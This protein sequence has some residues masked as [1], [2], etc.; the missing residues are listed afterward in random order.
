MTVFLYP[1]IKIPNGFSPNGDTKNEKWIID[2]IDQFPD[3]TVEVYNRWGELLYYYNNY[4]GQFDGKF[5]GKD[6]PVGTYYYVI[7][8]N[9]P[10]YT[11][12]FTGPLTIFR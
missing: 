1:V 3:N 9:H 11:K 8:L 4:N 2:N 10:A 7:N 12:P 6:L 5:K